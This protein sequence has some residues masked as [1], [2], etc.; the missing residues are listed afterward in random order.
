MEALLRAVLDGHLGLPQALDWV[1]SAAS[2]PPPIALDDGAGSLAPSG[3][4]GLNCCTPAAFRVFVLNHVR[5]Q[6]ELI[7]AAAEQESAPTSQPPTPEAKGGGLPCG[8]APPRRPAGGQPGAPPP[9]PQAERPQQAPPPGRPPQPGALDD[10]NFP[11]LGAAPAARP[12]PAHQPAAAKGKALPRRKINAQP[13]DAVVVDPSFVTAQPGGAAPQLPAPAAQAPAQLRG[14]PQG[15]TPKRII[16]TKV[17]AVDV[18]PSFLA[19]PSLTPQACRLAGLLAQTPTPAAA[20]ASKTAGGAPARSPVQLDGAGEQELCCQLS[21][22]DTTSTG[23]TAAAGVSRGA[24]ADGGSGAGEPGAL[25]AS[26]E[27]RMCGVSLGSPAAG[28]LLASRLGAPAGRPAPTPPQRQP[29]PNQ[30]RQPEATGRSAAAATP[31]VDPSPME[32]LTQRLSTRLLPAGAST[33][34]GFDAPAVPLAERQQPQEQRLSAWPAQGTPSPPSAKPPS[35]QPQPQ[36]APGASGPHGPPPPAAPARQ[37]L[38]PLKRP[39]ASLEDSLEPPPSQQ[40]VAAL[41]DS[42]RVLAELHAGLLRCCSSINLAGELDLVLNL[43][44]VPPATR[45]DPSLAHV[46]PLWC[47]ELAQCYACCVLQSAGWAVRGLGSQL[48]Q[49]LSALPVVRAGFPRLHSTMQLALAQLQE[50]QL[51]TEKAYSHV[52][53]GGL[54]S[55]FGLPA[56]TADGRKSRSQAE[57]RRVANRESCRDEW[58]NLMK[59][60]AAQTHSFA[61]GQLARGGTSLA[62]PASESGRTGATGAGDEA[63]VML[64]MQQS[65]GDLLRRLRPDNFGAFAELFTAAAAAT[66]ETILDEELTSLA[67]K[68]VSR[69]HR[70]NQ[71]LQAQGA[72]GPSRGGAARL[73]QHAAATATGFGGGGAGGGPGSRGAR[74]RQGG[75]GGGAAGLEEGAAAALALVSQFPRAQRLYVLF[76]EAADSHRLNSALV[77]CMAAR[78]RG[79]REQAG[80]D[81]GA[82][83]AAL[84]ERVVG[85]ATLATF[86]GYLCFARGGGALADGG[87]SGAA[88][89]VGAAAAY[90]GS[91]PVDVC[92]ALEAAAADGSLPVALPWAVRYLWFVP[93]PAAAEPEASLAPY[94][95]RALAQLAGL[96]ASLALTPQ[97]EGF[98]LAALCLRSLLDDFLERVG[99]DLV[100]HSCRAFGGGA[101]PGGGGGPV[102]AG[103]PPPPVPLAGGLAAADGLLDSRYL[104]LCCPTLE[105]AHQ[106]FRATRAAASSAASGGGGG[107]P[108]GQQQLRR[109]KK[110]RPT[111]PSGSLARAALQVPASLQSAAAGGSDVIKLKL[112]RAFLE[113]YSTDAHKAR[114]RRGGG[115]AAAAGPR[116]P[117]RGRARPAPL[118][119]AA[120]PRSIT[121]DR[122]LV[123][124]PPRPPS[125]SFLQVKLKEVVDYVADVV[126]CNAAAWAAGQLVP[127]EL[128]ASGARLSEAAEQLVAA[129][130]A[131]GGGGGGTGPAQGIESAVRQYLG[132][133]GEQLIAA[134]CAAALGEG[135][136]LAGRQLEQNAVRAMLALVPP[137]LGDAVVGTAAAIAAEVGAAACAR[138]LLAQVPHGLRQGVQ[139]QVDAA[140]AAFAKGSRVAAAPRGSVP[141][142]ACGRGP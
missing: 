54:T 18:N 65:A 62:D 142:A 97:H 131:G 34:I 124:L 4:P 47:G 12:R 89:G 104:Q 15:A 69:F 116:R 38:S 137:G 55:L 32:R 85:M 60:A 48:L 100:A 136:A 86:L 51:R 9:R 112:Q 29:P 101:G 102:R 79:L 49:D 135:Q 3:P 2:E 122:L 121:L 7:L 66:G 84:S 90:D 99:P 33:T 126:A 42:A 57:Q 78:L 31:S 40:P 77:R 71:R 109:V 130:A 52:R 127:R 94:F 35:P 72:A 30:Q 27:Q 25:P 41:A 13:V 105:H 132:S 70:L 73:Q 20:G 58:F 141:Q 88:A 95:Q 68:N 80:G 81:H 92:A 24:A 59:E 50:R 87:A 123:P 83:G 17:A 10:S 134:A 45:V 119:G 14:P 46:T 93:G 114:G 125:G 6:A 22:D 75:R 1:L 111:A 138:H 120:L 96:H 63:S 67:Q 91:H 37:S 36:Q 117:A 28:G 128:E 115:A 103:G 139:Q 23:R 110:I 133:L 11:A 113:Q 43:L 106:L 140:I 108:G 53:S 8:G 26:L 82:A 21:F 74:M 98:D 64:A 129:L 56:L 39:P 76:L 61:A 118:A 44:A 5:E 107:Q 16:P 19:S